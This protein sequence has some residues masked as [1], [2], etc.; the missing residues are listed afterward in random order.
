MAGSK[1][2]PLV[3]LTDAG[4]RPHHRT[5]GLLSTPAA[6]SPSSF[7]GQMHMYNCKHLA[8]LMQ[9]KVC[10]REEKGTLADNEGHGSD[11]VRR[12]GGE[13]E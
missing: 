2:Q 6:T 3:Q 7:Y 4:D 12:A 5:P 13:R 11:G 1:F 8:T 10:L 9:L